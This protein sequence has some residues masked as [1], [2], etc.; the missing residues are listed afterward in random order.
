L[1][2][3]SKESA[4]VIGAGIVGLAVARALAIR[5]HTVTVL[6]RHQRAVGASVRNFGSLWLI[7]VPNG[8]LYERALRSRSIWVGL[9][10]DMRL[11]HDACGSLH[12]A[13]RD[14]ELQV[15]EQY[16]EL[17]RGV[18]PCR[19]VT[20]AAARALVP[21]L[22]AQ[23]LEGGMLCDDELLLDPREAIRALPGYLAER[24]GVRFRWGVAANHIESGRVWAGRESYTAE[25]VYICAGA[26]FEWLFPQVFADAP[27][28]RCKLQMMRLTPEGGALRLGPALATG[29]SLVH[30]ASFG[31]V[32]QVAQVRA[33]LESE[34][35]DLLEL[36][37]QLLVMQNGRGEIAVGDSH[38]YG[39]THEPFDE[40]SINE[41][42][43][44]CMREVLQL[45]PVRLM[46]TWHGVYAKLT[47]GGSE[48]VREASPGVTIVNGLGGLGMTLSFG[49]AEELIERRYRPAI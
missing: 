14:D 18:R 40:Q 25:R 16:V 22:R 21:P 34:R 33:R 48:L 42:I 7:G 26:D 19:M 35:P 6:E 12:L 30:Y 31:V 39:D 29:L 49:L 44:E 11:W 45:P 17:N 32:P 13:R 41:K 24:H 2:V 15:L 3:V 4:I 1:V 8:L 28:T 37:I 47:D 38:V 10:R 20:A 9:L 5:G 36:G 46:Q 23:G 27:I 43:L